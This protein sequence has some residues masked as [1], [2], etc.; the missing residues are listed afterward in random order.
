MMEVT[1]APIVDNSDDIIIDVG[2]NEDWPTGA[3]VPWAE[4]DALDVQYDQYDQYNP[5]VQFEQPYIPS[6]QPTPSQAQI[7]AE[8]AGIGSKASERAWKHMQTDA[9]NQQRVQGQFVK[10]MD[11]SDPIVQE[12]IP[13]CRFLNSYRHEY[14]GK[15]N[16]Q[17]KA[18][19]N[20]ADPRMPL[21]MLESW[22][23]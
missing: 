16:F 10:E 18:D 19:Y 1:E 2:P 12:K 20:P 9:Y 23:D 14:K 3:S 6:I 15:I 7:N 4:H 22:E 13:I 8:A 21:P 17:F 11:M 5:Q